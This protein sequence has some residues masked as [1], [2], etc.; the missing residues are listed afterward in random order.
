MKDYFQYDL[1]VNLNGNSKNK[2]F[3]SWTMLRHSNGKTNLA[4]LWNTRTSFHKVPTAAQGTY[5]CTR[6]LLLHKVP[7]AAQDAY[8]CTRYILLHKMPTA[9]Q[10]TYCCTRYLLVHKVPTAAQGAY[11]CT[12]YLLL[13]KVPTAVQSAYCCT[14]YLLLHKVSTAAQ[15]TYCC[16]K[17]LLCTR[18]ILLHNVPTAAQGAYCCTRYLL[19]HKV[20]TALQSVY[21]CTK[22]LLLHSVPTA[23][24]IAYCCT[25]CLL[26]HE[27]PTA[28]QGAYCCTRCLLLHKVPTAAQGAYCCTKC[29]LLQKVLTAAQSAYCCTVPLGRKTTA[30]ADSG[31][32]L[33]GSTKRCVKSDQAEIL[34]GRTR[35]WLN[36][37]LTIRVGLV[38]KDSSGSIRSVRKNRQPALLNASVRERL[39]AK[40]KTK[41][42]SA[43]HFALRTLKTFYV[44]MTKIQHIFQF[45]RQVQ[46]KCI[47]SLL[48]RPDIPRSAYCWG[49]ETTLR[50]T[51]LGR[52]PLDAWSTR[53]RNLHLH[54]TQHTQ[55]TDQPCPR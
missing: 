18:Y 24:Q 37:L 40:W 9:A 28:T 46:V 47:F 27:V 22:Y 2:S 30:S 50:H 29:L 36:C 21:C 20:P 35:L 16:T 42:K 23:E 49:S 8:C 5:C 54:N 55:E 11:F 48:D 13:H 41:G 4:C 51:T 52:T 34:T 33:H 1:T 7:T 12:R 15:G 38:V 25:R 43:V 39:P 3:V 26:L 14:R 45:G 6:C 19:L 31:F 17:C 53:R 44:N 32:H 10:G